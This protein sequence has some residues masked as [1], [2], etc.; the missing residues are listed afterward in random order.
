MDLQGWALVITA[1][2]GALSAVFT[3]AT[4]MYAARTK[5]G[6]EVVKADVAEV[7]QTVALVEKHSNSMKDALVKATG[8]AS[9]LEGERSG[10]E[11]EEGRAAIAAQ[12]KVVIVQ[13]D[14]AEVAANVANVV[15]KP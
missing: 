1:L 11:K 2:G 6:V 5:A 12:D 13:A 9:F 8:D 3:A 4:L 14:V 15:E 7:K 10:R